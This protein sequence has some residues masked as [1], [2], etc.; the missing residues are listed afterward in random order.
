MN[1]PYIQSL[2]KTMPA[3]AILFLLGFSVISVN[4]GMNLMKG[5]DNTD[6]YEA[7][8]SIA[9]SQ[10]DVNNTQVESQVLQSESEIANGLYFKTIRELSSLEYAYGEESYIEPY[11]VNNSKTVTEKRNFGLH[12]ICGAICLMLGAFQFWPYF[13]RKYRKMHRVFG[14]VFILSGVTLSISVWFYLIWSGPEKTYEGITG[15]AGLY[16]LSGIVLLSMGVS[17]FYLC[18]RE[19]NKHMGWMSIAFGS[20]LTAPFQR[21][22]WMVLAALDTGQTHAV[23]NGLV[24]AVLYT[25]AYAVA[26]LIFFMNR[27][28]SPIKKHFT[29]Y[30]Y[31]SEIKKYGLIIIS[32]LGSISV[33]YY[34]FLTKGMAESGAVLGIINEKAFIKETAV[35]FNQGSA[36]PL[37]FATLS[38]IIM[39]LGAYLFSTKD[40]LKQ[41]VNPTL[42]LYV[43]AGVGLACIEISW[44]LQIGYPTMLN[45]PGGGHYVLWGILHLSFSAAVFYAHLANKQSL[46]K[47]WI[48]MLW[49]LSFFSVSIFWLASGLSVLNVV[50]QHYIESRHISVLLA[51]GASTF[52]F[53]LAMIFAIYGIATKER[54]IH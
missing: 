5:T 47:E 11:I 23:I 6:A 13:R 2:K 18:K 36:I 41:G 15:Q 19:Y 20:F 8:V 28:F 32:A 10:Q 39:C 7:L 24:D 46:L 31:D 40:S 9:A 25:Q 27:H 52:I 21:Y 33:F 4:T 26:Y 42:Y 54:A 48:M 49:V 53:L 35:I 12:M 44:G 17:V 30:A 50:P 22:D 3:I 34:Y 43:L 45:S 38:T 1:P 51:G 14:S 16:T 37:M 29:P